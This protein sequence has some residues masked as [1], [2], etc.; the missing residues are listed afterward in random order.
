MTR[1]S[2]KRSAGSAAAAEISGSWRIEKCAIAFETAG[3]VGAHGF[4]R[5]GGIP[6][7]DRIDNAAMLLLDAGEVSGL[8]FR[9]GV[10]KAYALARDDELPEITQELDEEAVTS[11]F[12]DGTVQLDVS[13][14]A[15]IAPGEGFVNTGERGFDFAAVLTGA[16]LG[17]ERGRFSLDGNS[18]FHHVEDPL[19]RI[20]LVGIDAERA[21]A[22]RFG[23]ECADALAGDHEAF[24]AE[25]GNGFAHNSSADAKRRDELLLGGKLGPGGKG[26]GKDLATEALYQIL[27]QAPHRSEGSQKAEWRLDLGFMSDV[28][29]HCGVFRVPEARPGSTVDVAGPACFYSLYCHMTC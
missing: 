12:G 7:R 14:D 10:V 17:G 29:G 20:E 28:T 18:Q 19:Q 5:G 9:T 27:G 25:C 23:H 6:A 24:G 16:A 22:G 3:E 26:A 2:D 11:G 15:R 4:A 13:L 1:R 21:M 8:S